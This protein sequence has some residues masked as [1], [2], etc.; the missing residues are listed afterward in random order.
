M[1]DGETY[2]HNRS[3]KFSV[4]YRDENVD[5]RKVLGKYIVANK[6]GYWLRFSINVPDTGEYDLEAR[7]A[8]GHVRHR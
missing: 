4:P 2:H 1:A 3:L 6:P 8:R 7:L 5:I